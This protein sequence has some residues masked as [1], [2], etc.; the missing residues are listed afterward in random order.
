MFL[1]YLFVST[2]RDVS[3]T[4]A[5]SHHTTVLVVQVLKD[6]RFLL[7]PHVVADPRIKMAAIFATAMGSNIGGFSFTFASSLAGLLWS[8]ILRQK[9]IIV[10]AWYASTFC[11]F[12][13]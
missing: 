6:D 1:P 7:A 12:F 5:T 8:N 10:T 2:C 11:L 4:R 3:L 13:L 9:G